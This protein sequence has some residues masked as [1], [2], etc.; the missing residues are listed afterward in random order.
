MLAVRQA[1]SRDSLA[2]TLSFANAAN[3][4]CGKDRLKTLVV[5]Q[6]SNDTVHSVLSVKK[7]VGFR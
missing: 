5:R 3:S 7:L 6:P 4:R 1:L 2:V